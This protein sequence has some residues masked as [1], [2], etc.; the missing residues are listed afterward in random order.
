MHFEFTADYCL[1]CVDVALAANLGVSNR[2]QEAIEFAGRGLLIR[3]R[4]LGVLSTKTAESHFQLGNLYTRHDAFDEGYRELLAGTRP[5]P[6]LG[7]L[8]FPPASVSPSL[9]CLVP[10]ACV[11]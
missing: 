5:A 3:I 10:C 2:L 8:L 9:L 7:D 1:S 6:S 11:L 4:V